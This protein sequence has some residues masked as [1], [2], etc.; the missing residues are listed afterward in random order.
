M[1]PRSVVVI[2][3]GV[4]GIAAAIHLAHHGLHVTVLDKNDYPGGRCDRLIRDGHYFD[5]GPTLLIM[6][7]IYEAEFLSLGAS[8]RE[9]LDLHTRRP[10]LPSGLR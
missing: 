8:L 9:M 7:L 10:N 3:A 5:T 4:G 1:K 6:P 2:G